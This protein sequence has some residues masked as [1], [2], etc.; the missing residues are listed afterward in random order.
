MIASATSLTPSDRSS[1]NA[2]FFYDRCPAALWC[3]IY[4]GLLTFLSVGRSSHRPVRPG[5]S[6]RG[7]SIDGSGCGARGFGKRVPGARAATGSTRRH[8]DLPPGAGRRAW[9]VHVLASAARTPCN[10]TAAARR[11]A[12]ACFEKS[13]RSTERV[14][15]LIGA[16]RPRHMSRTEGTR[17]TRRQPNNTGDHPR[18]FEMRIR[19][20]RAQTSPV[21]RGARANARTAKDLRVSLDLIGNRRPFEARMLAHASAS[22][23]RECQFPV[24]ASSA[25]ARAR[26]G[27][28]Y[29]LP[30]MPTAP[31]PGFAAKAATIAFP[32]SICAADGVNTSLITGT[33]AG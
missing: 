20:A 22:G 29:I 9:L 10:D 11:E 27:R 23:W 7:V 4:L 14:S 8:Q 17:R 13:M 5:A 12:R 33:C 25:C 31:A 26:C 1:D 15:R 2:Q 3:H 30:S 16:R 19:D 21:V 28:S 18:L 32:F 6:S 24:R